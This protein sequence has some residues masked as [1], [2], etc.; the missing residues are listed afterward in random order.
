MFQLSSIY[1]MLHV[2]KLS[3]MVDKYSIASRLFLQALFMCPLDVIVVN[4]QGCYLFKRYRGLFSFHK[5]MGRRQNLL[6]KKHA[7]VRDVALDTRR[8]KAIFYPGR[9]GMGMSCNESVGYPDLGTQ[10]LRLFKS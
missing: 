2:R 1:L 5:A 4:M 8:M 9:Q 3:Y 6:S 7:K 10:V